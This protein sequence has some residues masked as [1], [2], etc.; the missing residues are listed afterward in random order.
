MSPR[1]VPAIFAFFFFL[2]LAVPAVRAIGFQPVSPDE[3]KMT[4]EPQAPGAPAIIL[5]RQVDRD[6]NGHTSHEDNY[7]RV[8]ILTEEGRKYADIEMP[9]RKGMESIVSVHGRTIRPDGSIAEFDG[10]V[11]DKSIVKSRNLKVQAKTF[12]LPDVQVG[13]II[14]YYYTNDLAEDEVFESRWI[15]SDELFTKSAK[16]SLKPYPN[17]YGQFHFWWTWNYLPPGTTPPAEGPDHIIRLEAH[18]IPAVHT[19]DFMPPEEE[20][21]SRVDFV[22]SEEAP[23]NSV[24]DYW[25]KTDKKL[26]GE[27]DSYLGKKKA[28]EEAVGQIVSPSDPPEVK[29][30]KIYARVQQI[31]NTSFEVQKT[32]EEVKREKEKTA[33]NAEDLWKRGYGDGRHITWLF[34]ALARAAGLEAYGVWVS[35]RRNYFFS[36]KL[37]DSRRLDEN[38][39]LVK[40]SGKDLYFDPGAQFTPCGLL[41]W[42]E[43]SVK[44]L[45]LD[46]DGGSW[47]ETTLPESAESRIE[48]KAELKLSQETGELEGKLTVTYTGLEALSR[49]VNERNEDDTEHKKFLEDEV[50]EFVP[51][52]IEVELTNK[53]EWKS[54]DP[55]LVAE[56][57]LKI[58]G[59]VSSAGR[60]VLLPVGIFSGPE[61][62]MFDHANRE[63]AI[64]F[65]YPS[66]RLDDV[67]VEL[68]AGWQVSSLPPAAGQ[69]GH[70]VGYTMKAENNGGKVHVS[71]TLNIDFLVLET[72]YYSAL[73]KFY[74]EVRS[75]DEEQIV[76][77]PGTTTANN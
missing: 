1:H 34:L 59:W 77:Q 76:L 61:K 58:P 9:F 35:E 4:S 8:K 67:T 40:L 15:L 7:F 66:Q 27:L 43:T 24:D 30:Q 28:M 65:E 16:F 26:N 6:D 56:F 18:N 29:L 32:E 19:E 57:S 74:Q 44:G 10:K 13:S 39:V 33:S 42:S 11:F 2:I 73:R 49:R 52:G 22:Y 41:P 48:R 5:F 68:P 14:E 17:N 21:K 71:R 25:K 75:G 55:K 63:N 3:L 50:K 60:R 38:V 54:S 45:R 64:Y 37:M 53:P 70:I 72:K 51:T 23:G 46:K 31:R 12:T 69:N 36:E 20:L 47:V 62:H